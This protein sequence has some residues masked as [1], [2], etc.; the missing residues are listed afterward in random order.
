M[1]KAREEFLKTYRKYSGISED[2][3][4]DLTKYRKV[5]VSG[6]NKSEITGKSR[7]TTAYKSRE[8]RNTQNPNQS[9]RKRYTSKTPVR[10][11]ESSK[12]KIR[13]QK[14]SKG[15][16]KKFIILGAVGAIALG[17]YGA[18]ALY[19]NYKD[20]QN[21]VSLSQ[22]LSYKTLQDLGIDE[23][24]K[25]NLYKLEGIVGREDLAEDEKKKLLEDIKILSFDV[26]K[27]KLA[28]AYNKSIELEE[29]TTKQVDERRSKQK[30]GV[31]DIVFSVEDKEG[32]NE[33]SIRIK[34]IGNFKKNKI[35][36]LEAGGGFSNEINDFVNT[37]IDIQNE[38]KRL[39]EGDYDYDEASNK[40]RYYL[41]RISK[42]AAGEITYQDGNFYYQ[43]K[44]V[45][46]YKKE[47]E[48]NNK[49]KIFLSEDTER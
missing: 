35:I 19:N 33:I 49:N 32:D 39:L 7:T 38:E 23:N 11:K 10:T 3:V 13:T 17:A 43:T 22:A 42:F 1:D 29:Q 20:S 48:I 15:V 8:K 36:K 21:T 45:S 14:S 2:V 28:N 31:E 44:R 30:I 40:Y 24:L 4:D 16:M 47:K 18:N 37:I 25:E 9:K 27:T 34:D 5:V 41:E 12:G 46:E 6:E 26:A